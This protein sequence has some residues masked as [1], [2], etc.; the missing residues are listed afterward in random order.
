MWDGC[1][2]VTFE[3]SCIFRDK[4]VTIGSSLKS[5]C[6][7]KLSLSKSLV[8]SVQNWSSFFVILP[9][10]RRL[11]VCWSILLLASF[12]KFNDF[13][14]I[15]FRANGFGSSNPALLKFSPKLNDNPFFSQS[16]NRMTK[17]QWKLV[18][19]NVSKAFHN[20]DVHLRLIFLISYLVE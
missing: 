2:C 14:P 6:Q 19:Q 16:S 11:F 9:H 5:N 15:M 13:K 1:F 17:L 3:A 4:L 7:I 10:K 12:D 18:S 20:S 8:N